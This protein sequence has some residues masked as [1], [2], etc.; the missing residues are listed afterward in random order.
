M[1][2]MIVELADRQHKFPGREIEG[3]TYDSIV[4]PAPAI[5]GLTHQIRRKRNVRAG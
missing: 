5:K 2:S 3:W 4:F 1:S